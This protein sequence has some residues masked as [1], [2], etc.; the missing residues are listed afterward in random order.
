MDLSQ[1]IVWNLYAGG[2]AALTALVAKKGLDGAWSVVTGEE[3]P[4]LA[5]PA[6]PQRTALTWALLVAVGLG[7]T[8]V[9]VNRFAARQWEKYS[10]TAAPARSVNFRL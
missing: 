3:P 10:G 5:D 1:K 4:D 8:Q 7:V 9:F 6:V 2:I